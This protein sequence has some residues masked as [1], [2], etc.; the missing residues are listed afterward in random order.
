MRKTAIAYLTAMLVT[1]PIITAVAAPAGP[2]RWVEEMMTA[3][4]VLTAQCPPVTRPPNAN[5]LPIHVTEWGTSG[6]TVLFVHGGV[7]G[8]FAGDGPSN[9]AEQKP[10]SEQ[11]WRL[12]LVDRPGFGQ[13]PTRGP[14]DEEADAIWIARELGDS[15][16][17]VGHSFGG[18]EALLAAARRP[19]AV[20][21]L[22]LVEPAL[23][24]VLATE[25]ESFND[26]VAKDAMLIVGKFF[27]TART[28]GELAR[29][30]SVSL[31]RGVY[32]GEN[33]AVA[34]LDAH[35]ETAAAL[36]C[37]VLQANIAAPWVMRDAADT[38]ARAHIPV[39]VIS[40]GYNS[41]QDKTGEVIARLTHGRH[42]IVRSPNHFI[43]QSNPADFNKVA[44]DFMRAADKGR[45]ARSSERQN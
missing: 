37:A 17:L 32:G 22:I 14:D 2:P 18:A 42:V 11:G 23:Q 9:F 44:A 36:G 19:Q 31:G 5:S 24:P 43:Q 35:P 4:A 33:I 45:T 25:A 6:P 27:I 15:A 21:S 16:H 38:V 29:L 26:P 8:T 28:P 30:F 1:A 41:G 7:Q 10:L 12:K 34:A 13:S 3:G 39:L 40:G 20:R